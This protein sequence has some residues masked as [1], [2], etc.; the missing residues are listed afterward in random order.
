MPIIHRTE[1]LILLPGELATLPII[2]K[3]LMR[4]FGS[5][6]PRGP[7]RNCDISKQ[8]VIGLGVV[9]SFSGARSE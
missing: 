8:I 6:V 3:A 1:V 5:F 7:V 2:L 9:G 4:S